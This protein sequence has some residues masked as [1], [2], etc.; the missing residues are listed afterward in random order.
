MIRIDLHSSTPVIDQITNELKHAI[1]RGEIPPGASLPPVRQLAGDLGIHW[2][3]VARAYR[4]LATD[5]YLT[6]VRGRGATVRPKSNWPHRR[7]G[8]RE[9]IREKITHI[10]TEGTLAGLQPDDLRNLFDS[11]L[12]KW[13]KRGES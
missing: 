10:L 4:E 6:V 7:A 13:L 3:T 2:N 8:I 1:A 12:S 5:G 9:S 11:E